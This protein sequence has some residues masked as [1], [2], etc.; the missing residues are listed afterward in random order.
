[1]EREA[2]YAA[3]GAFVLTVVVMTALF[4]YWY[5]DA[6]EHRHYSRYEIYFDGSV[7]GLT[8]GAAVRYLGVDVGRV[9]AMH[10]DP[11]S[12]SR[13]QVIVDIDA[14]TPI[15]ERTVAQL[16]LQ[17]V[18]GVL[19]IDLLR[20]P[21]GQPLAEAVPSEQYPVIRSTRSNFDV[22]LS[23]LPQMVGLA[24][25]AIE[26]VDRMLSDE[27]VAAVS[28]A[29]VNLDRA[30]V[31]LPATLGELRAMLADLTRT[32][33]EMRET[34]VSV[35][36]IAQD[37]GPRLRVTLERMSGVAENLSRATAQL[38]AIV[39]E[40]RADVRA[41]ARDGLPQLEGLLH[42]GRDAVAELRDLAHSLR[43]DPSQVIYQPN[44]GGVTIPR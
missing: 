10:I 26:R 14:T 12:A 29:V 44:P 23:S 19:Y 42:D 21:A 28:E 3:V 27:N 15:S 39:R 35:R 16:S 22:L 11:R 7:A 6:R 41:F 36:A 43:D 17:G 18:T 34:V 30:S 37:S 9:T 38:E 20:N 8:R 32:S 33:A 2:N 13:V 1:M 4:V 25:G 31:A 40:N 5:S 24:S